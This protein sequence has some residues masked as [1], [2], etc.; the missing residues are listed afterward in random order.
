MS[1]VA[2][3][4]S[5]Q[6]AYEKPPTGNHPAVLVAIIDLG[7]Q[8][9]EPFDKAEPGKFQHRLYFVYELVTKKMTGKVNE[10]HT[11]AVD[12]TFSMHEKATMRKYIESRLGKKI[13][14][15]QYDVTQEL[16]QA[17]L[18]SV[19]EN[20]NGYPKIGGVSAV[21]DG[22]PVPPALNKVLAWKLGDSFAAIPPWLPYLYGRAIPEVIRDSEEYK[23]GTVSE[24]AGENQAGQSAAP[25]RPAVARPSRAAPQPKP[26][27]LTSTATWF[28]WDDE[29]KDWGPLAL[30]EI[31]SWYN[32]ARID[33]SAIRVY[34]D[35]ETPEQA[36]T[37]AEW[38]FP[39]MNPF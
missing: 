21:P 23:S 18:L 11:V 1:W 10:N 35:G 2:K 24:R 31:V 17:V 5:G 12:L 7:R 15:D 6:G 3:T 14:T 8:W 19:V 13:V 25:G 39:A 27:D 36:K 30:Q 16:G 32:E 9:Q 22:L 20:K 33:P 34:P 38:G 37:A 26:V 28:V 29:Q 4:T